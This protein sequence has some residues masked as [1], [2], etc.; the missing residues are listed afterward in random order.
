MLEPHP[1]NVS[2]IEHPLW[3]NWFSKMRE[4]INNG[5]QP[6]D[7][8][9]IENNSAINIT[10]PLMRVIGKEGAIALGNPQII[11]FGVTDGYRIKIKGSDDTKTVSISDGSGVRLI[12]V[13]PFVLKKDYMIGLHYDANDNVWIEE[14]RNK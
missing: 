1:E 8:V 5:F 3:K 12:G 9:E 13:S 10:S 6:S 2:N 11:L 14:F 4:I 7:I